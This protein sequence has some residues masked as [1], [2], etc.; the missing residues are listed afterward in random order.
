MGKP[1]FPQLNWYWG[2]LRVH[3]FSMSFPR[4]TLPHLRAV[5]PVPSQ[6]PRDGD[7]VSYESY[8]VATPEDIFQL[9][10]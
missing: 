1:I 5:S 6:C 10:N 4:Y 7:A 8:L 9:N 3:V 2:E